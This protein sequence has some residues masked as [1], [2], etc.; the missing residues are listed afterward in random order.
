MDPFALRAPWF[1]AGPLIGLA[2][3]LHYW[4]TRRPTG[5]TDGYIDLLA[6]ARQ[7]RSLPRY[8]VFVLIGIALGGLLASFLAGTLGVPTSDVFYEM[9][10]GSGSGRFLLL[11][12]AGGLIGFG[13]RA[14]ATAT[15]DADPSGHPFDSPTLLVNAIV[16]L[17]VAAV[18]SWLVDYMMSAP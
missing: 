16:F 13:L 3:V 12:F 2:V 6:W 8:T 10:Y 15:A 7:P 5:A 1:L 4:F 18:T 11:L 14:T 17:G 9:R